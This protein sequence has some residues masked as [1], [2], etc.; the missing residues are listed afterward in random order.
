MVVPYAVGNH[1]HVMPR[2]FSLDAVKH[3]E[4]PQKHHAAAPM[5]AF[6]SAYDNNTSENTVLL[7]YSRTVYSYTETALCNL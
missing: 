1:C 6:P 5:P 3:K 7:T 2:V 4:R